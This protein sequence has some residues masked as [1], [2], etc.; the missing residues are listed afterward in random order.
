MHSL[1]RLFTLLPALFL[2][3]CL[4]IDALVKLKPDGSGTIEQKAMMGG[5]MVAQMKSMA[6]AFG[7]DKAGGADGGIYDEAKLKARAAEMGK[8]VTYV[9]SKKETAADGSEGFTAVYTFTDI[10]QLKLKADPGDFGPQGGS[11]KMKSS[12]KEPPMTFQFTKGQP[13]S[14]KIINPRAK[15]EP[16]K[17]ADAAPSPED[18][19]QD[20][21]LPMMQQMLKDMRMTVAVEVAGRITETNA[22]W[23]DGSRVT[24]VDVEMNKMLADPAKFK[25]MTKFKDPN[26]AEAKAILASVPGIKVETAETVTLKFQ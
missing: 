24:L 5:A 18:A 15:A 23:K 14:L 6:A 13:A 26:S 22:Q 3:G 4:Q 25:A 11:V 9:S 10:N 17:K 21:M 7:G 1:S 20:A 16:A 8:G 12:G 2:T 19:M